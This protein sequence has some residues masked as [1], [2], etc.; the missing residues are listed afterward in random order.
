MVN[1]CIEKKRQRE[2]TGSTVQTKMDV[3][4]DD[5]VKKQAS[6]NEEDEFF[7]CDDDE[8]VMHSSHKKGHRNTDKTIK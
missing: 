6:D 2:C 5:V 1:C 8:E 4:D 7:D 3:D